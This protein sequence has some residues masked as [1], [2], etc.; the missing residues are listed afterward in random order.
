MTDNTGIISTTANELEGVI[1]NTANTVT[2]SQPGF[3]SLDWSVAGTTAP[4]ITAPGATISSVKTS[5]G[6]VDSFYSSLI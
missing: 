5:N 6:L 2:I 3:Y 4:S 1:R